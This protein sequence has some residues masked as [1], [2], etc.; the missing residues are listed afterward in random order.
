MDGVKPSC[1]GL[2]DF[3]KFCCNELKPFLFESR[4]YFTS[5]VPLYTIGLD[6]D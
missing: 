5:Q 4:D 6:D 2:G 3:H 1:E